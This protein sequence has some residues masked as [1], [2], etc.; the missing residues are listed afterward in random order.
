[1]RTHESRGPLGAL[2][3]AWFALA[4]MAQAQNQPWFAGVGDLA[5]GA[6]SSIAEAISADA[7]TVVGE[8]ESTPG[9][10]AF[11]W[12]AAGGIVGL[13]DLAGGQFL[14][15]AA[16]VS[17]NG[18][19][20]AG[21]GVDASDVSRAFRWTQ[22]GG[23]VALNTFSCF[24]CDPH[25]FAEGISAN[26]LVVFGAGMRKG[27][28]GDAY[29]ESARWTGGGTSISGMGHLSGGG[30][31]SG[32]AGASSDGATIVGDSD[33]STGIRGTW[34]RSSGGLVALANWPGAQVA[35]GATAI[36][37]DATTIVGFANTSATSV[38]EK[39]AMRWTGTN[40]ATIQ[41]L[42]SLPGSTFLDSRAFAVTN[43]GALIVGVANDENND[44]AAFL[45]DAAHG[46]RKL[47][48]VLAEDYGL[49]LGGWT[50]VD[51]RG[52]S[53]K[54][55]AGEFTI[56]GA[57]V[58][59]GGDPEGYVARLS[60]TACNDGIDNDGD[61]Q[62]DF[63][64]DAGCTRRADRSELPD[65]ADGL[66]QDGDGQADY[67]ADAQCSSA[68]DTTE[69]PDCSDGIDRDGDTFVD[70]PAD[71]GCR[72]AAGLVEN[73]ACDNDIDD[74]SDGATDFPL[75]AGCL[76]AD[77][78]SE[79]ADC[80]DGID[81]DGD[82]LIDHPADPDCT[83]VSDRSEDPQCSDRVDNEVDGR[84]DYPFD[85]PD[86]TS[87]SDTVEKPACSDG[88]DNDGDGFI[89]FPADTGCLAA[90]FGSEA[91]TALALGDLLVADRDGRRLFKVDRATGAQTL[92]SSGAQFSAPQGLA[93][94][95]TGEIVVA[96]PAGLFEVNPQTGA[97][98]RFSTALTG[99]GSLQLVFDAAG[100][101]VVLESTGLRRVAWKPAGLGAETTLLALPVGT[102]LTFFQGDSLARE[103][104]GNL[105]VTGFGVGGDGVYRIGPTGAPIQVLK[106]GFT[107]DVW[108]DLA[109]EANGNLIAVGDDFTTGPGVY[110]I[111]PVT[112]LA[113]PL[114]TGAAW[115]EP[116]GVAVALDGEIFVGDAGN[117]TT[118]GC[119][120]ASL[121][122][123]NATT[124][125]RMSVWSGGFITG[126]TD[127]AIVTSLPACSNGADD[128]GDATIDHPA[129]VGCESPA[130]TNERPACSDGAD[131]DGDGFTDFPADNGCKAATSATES[132][133]CSDGLDN[134]GDGKID[135]DGGP[136]AGIADPN[137]K[138]SPLTSS[139]SG[140]KKC[141]LGAE[142]AF[143]L[144]ALHWLRRAR[145]RTTDLRWQH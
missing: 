44:D 142:A 80:N 133:P 51:A 75:D 25:A 41:S 89:D 35:S 139:E 69:E 130:D 43:D 27:L 109:L 70:Y 72:S 8:S 21:T 134:D 106:P 14:S 90:G 30:D 141:G 15:S 52:V 124:G 135:F 92:L 56:V 86:C 7:T 74:D 61:G 54:N 100:D 123:V 33:S 36:S 76:A 42:G 71:P 129:D 6:A 108:N 128:D 77:D 116:S 39:Q 31:A 10:Q 145:R 48:T 40:Y 121:V 143:A 120:G 65:C 84:T 19:V 117:C 47:S 68:A 5:G 58:N 95:S 94:R 81:D 98:R 91:P 103:S 17:S 140:T 32:A 82:G 111:D 66:D 63:P 1:M 60:P 29:L 110:R 112:G 136:A 107:T 50:L 34:W 37:S 132:P 4:P 22:A 127:L 118:S 28:F 67:P 23:L 144:A 38:N 101:A 85:Y 16:A 64:S 138:G 97:Q 49:D 45:W 18:S 9:T 55:A 122:R 13:G 78:Q 3:I 53:N 125:A 46:M 126:P 73:P 113:A 137:C 93:V 102:T 26:G 119:T 104:G 12:T 114:S 57:G 24:G 2:V 96:D 87:A 115:L 131:N 59:S 88:A 62:T 11:R 20:I 99:F 105:L 83:S 79:I